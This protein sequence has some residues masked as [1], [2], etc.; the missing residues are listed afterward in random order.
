MLRSTSARRALA[1]AA[2]QASRGGSYGSY[3]ASSGALLRVPRQLR[4]KTRRQC[5]AWHARVR[6][7]QLRS[8]RLL[9]QL[10]IARHRRAASCH[11]LRHRLPGVEDEGLRQ[12]HEAKAARRGGGGKERLVAVAVCESRVEGGTARRA[13]VAQHIRLIA[14][15]RLYVVRRRC[16]G[17][18]A[19]VGGVMCPCESGVELQTTGVLRQFLL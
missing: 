6:R 1:S 4:E 5:M 17:P 15:P 10:S 2:T 16:A 8:E 7:L 11:L 14:R 3:S 18:A 19:A 9:K 12:H 13:A